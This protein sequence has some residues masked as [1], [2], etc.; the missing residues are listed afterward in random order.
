M[1]T[2]LRRRLA[3]CALRHSIDD[4]AK[5]YFQKTA[6]INPVQNKNIKPELLAHIDELHDRAIE[7]T[8][9]PYRDT[10]W[11]DKDAD[12]EG[13]YWK[14]IYRVVKVASRRELPNPDE[15]SDEK[16]CI[17]SR[18]NGNKFVALDA[19]SD[20]MKKI[21]IMW[22]CM[23]TFEKIPGVPLPEKSTS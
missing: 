12:Q 10:P 11:F 16:F 8:N 1:T 6:E 3:R 22:K 2:E 14:S 13:R 15:F 21:E 9:T 23:K 4:F 19:N 5:Q 7:W 20:W 18:Q 17:W